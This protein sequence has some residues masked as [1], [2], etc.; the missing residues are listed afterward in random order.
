[1]GKQ[2]QFYM[3]EADED[4]FISYLR[5]TGDVVIVPQTS[6]GKLTEEFRSFRELAGREFGESCHLWNRSISSVPVLKHYPDKGYY[7]LDFMQSEVVN[8]MRSKMTDNG[9]SMGRLHI[10]DKARNRDGSM[11]SK[12]DAFQTWFST[13]CRWIEG[14]SQRRVDG[15]HVLAGAE[16]MLEGGVAVTGHSF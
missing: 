2:I 15:A 12:S 11:T 14:R 9:L 7:W 16:E 6:S 8:V 3:S 10:E 13:L 4:A 1:M 5:T